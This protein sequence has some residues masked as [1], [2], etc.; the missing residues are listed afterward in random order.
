[1]REG[2]GMQFSITGKN[3]KK[4][5]VVGRLVLFLSFKY[6]PPYLFRA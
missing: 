5:D 2:I 3:I 4:P 6:L 1:M